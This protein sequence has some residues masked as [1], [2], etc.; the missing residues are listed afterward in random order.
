MNVFFVLTPYF[1]LVLMT[2]LSRLA[3]IRAARDTPAVLFVPGAFHQATVYDKVIEKLRMDNYHDLTAI[4]L[5]SVGSLAG[6][7]ADVAAVRHILIQRLENGKDVLL[8]GN[9]YG[10]TVIGEAVKGLQKDTASTPNHT[11]SDV[12]NHSPNGSRRGRILGLMFISGYMPYIT[13]VTQPES[14]PN[15]RVVSPSFFRFTDGGKVYWDNDLVNFPPEKT[16][17]NA[18]N[19]REQKIWVKRLKFSS[20]KAL[21]ANATYIPYTGDFKCT[22]VIGERDNSVPPAFAQTYIDQPGA[23]FNVERLDADHVPMLSKPDDV[24]NLIKKAVSDM[25]V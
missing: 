17:Y 7:D 19:P 21:A 22:Y 11:P 3:G 24:V 4:D 15:I 20:F 14:K 1:V 25:R 23:K 13:E 18:L 16:F 2:T 9:S 12:S 6:R 5:S 10:A 8:V